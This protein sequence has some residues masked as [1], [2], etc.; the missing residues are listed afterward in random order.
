MKCRDYDRPHHPSAPRNDAE[1]HRR[2]GI[3]DLVKSL[4]ALLLAGTAALAPTVTFA[5]TPGAPFED[6]MAQ[7]TLACT[8]CHGA[9][10]RAAP[11][12]FYP[13]L[14]GKPVG[15]LYNQLLH[16][17]DGRRHYGL[18]TRL[19]DPL[20]DAYLL[21][22]AQHF[23]SLDLP[24]TAPAPSRAPAEQLARG[25]QLALDGDARTGLPACAQCHGTAL[26]GVLPNTPG[27]LGLPRA[28]LSAQ[29]GAW[30]SGQRS[31]HAPDCMAAIAQRLAPDDLNAVAVW[32]SSVPVPADAKPAARLERAPPIACGSA[33]LP[34][35]R[36][37]P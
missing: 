35:G 6:T 29:M 34:A 27:L 15:Y 16:F 28:Y 5:A 24:Y 23:A 4:I 22:I 19:L 32:L 26:T 8:A 1:A 20:S 14:A 33:V 11:D 9:Q 2:Q 21:E 31:A 18:M 17:R 25:R 13:R 12:G 3:I 7:R 10:G 36:A 37:T 30:R